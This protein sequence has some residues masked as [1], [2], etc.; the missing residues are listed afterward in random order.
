MVDERELPKQPLECTRG[1]ESVMLGPRRG[2][3]NDIHRSA[4]LRPLWS[5]RNRYIIALYSYSSGHH[6]V[7]RRRY[8]Y[9]CEV[10]GVFGRGKTGRSAPMVNTMPKY[11]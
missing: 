7:Q 11:E 9:R 4:Y 6:P 1:C 2:Y 8:P 3:V 5:A 10:R